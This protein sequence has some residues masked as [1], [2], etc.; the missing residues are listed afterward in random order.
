MIT[1]TI[2]AWSAWAPGLS[3]SA[4]WRRW[5]QNPQPLALVGTPELKM[6]P[7]MQR[8]RFSRL[9]RMALQSAFDACPP[10]L[11]TEAATVFASRHGE[12]EVTLSLLRDVALDLPL[13]PTSFSH[14]VHNTPAGLFSIAAGNG[15][16]SSSIAGMRD[17]FCA[18]LVEALGLCERQRPRP[19]LLVVA[20]EALPEIFGSFD[21]ELPAAFALALLLEESV[22]AGDPAFRLEISDALEASKDGE[23]RLPQALQ[24]LT[25][26]LGELEFFVLPSSGRCWKFQRVRT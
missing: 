10:E 22:R 23:P 1:F 8:R 5:A 16:P 2:R 9:T 15:Q 13:S 12:L 3:S 20:D 6:I 24:F 4:D 11:L 25:W 21:D 19:T 17:T 14:S 18:G 7:P 26:M